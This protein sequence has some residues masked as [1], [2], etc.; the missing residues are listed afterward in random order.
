[1][2]TETDLSRGRKVVDMT[3]TEGWAIVREELQ[4]RIDDEVRKMSKIR[5]EKK[6]LQEIA[7]E[8][9]QHVE[10]IKGYQEVFEIIDDILIR[11]ENAE[12]V[13]SNK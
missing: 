6:G 4:A 1:M 2:S 12:S 5:I 11:K 7:A 13:I 3:K 10:R 8:Y 9:I